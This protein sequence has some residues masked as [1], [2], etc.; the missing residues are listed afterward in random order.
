MPQTKKQKE[1]SSYIE[2]VKKLPAVKSREALHTSASGYASWSRINAELMTMTWT[3]ANC[4]NRKIFNDKKWAATGEAASCATVA[5]LSDAPLKHI[6]KELAEAFLLTKPVLGLNGEHM[7]LPVFLL[8]LP[9]GLFTDDTGANVNTIIVCSYDHWVDT[10]ATVGI[11]ISKDKAFRECGGL[12]IVGLSDD[13]TQLIKTVS[14]QNAHNTTPLD[15]D[16]FLAEGYDAN[17][18]A[19]AVAKMQ[20]LVVNTIA[21]MAWRKD[22]LEIDPPKRASTGFGGGSCAPRRRPVH[23]IG[24]NYVAKRTTVSLQGTGA[25][26]SPHWRSGHWHTVKH[27]EGRK[28]AKLLWFEPVYVNATES[29]PL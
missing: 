10:A 2:A 18:V 23:W 5:V 16:M 9:K 29:R 13:G 12:Q 19:S 24:K 28:R 7:P 3:L 4:S 27:G 14:W 17:L 11:R 1:W 20:R 22:L 25:G 15:D 6:G 26:K 21:A 8:N